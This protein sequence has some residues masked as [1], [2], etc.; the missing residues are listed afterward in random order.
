MSSLRHEQ[1]LQARL[2]YQFR[3]ASLL[4]LALTH[5]SFGDGRPIKDNE[6]MEFLGDRVLGLIVA[7]LLFL[8]AK[9]D[10]EGKM[11]RQLNALVC[12]E[13]CADAARAADLGAAL[14]L[15]KAEE[16]NGGRDKNSILGDVCEAVLGALYLD[17]GLKAA[18]GFFFQFWAEQLNNFSGSAKDPKSSL[19]EWALANQLG[20]PQ[21]SEIDRS[22]PDHRPEFQ[23]LVKLGKWTAKAK[24]FSKQ[25]AER[26]A[27]RDLLEQV[28][29]NDD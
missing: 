3:D 2:D 8:D 20:L 25:N 14:Y 17:G 26:E 19:Q 6:R 18:E 13:A 12:K 16:K 22:G 15:S 11:A 27:A 10:S 1:E 5:G 29:Q 9:E 7:N 28:S 21:Y 4:R 23:I 24:G